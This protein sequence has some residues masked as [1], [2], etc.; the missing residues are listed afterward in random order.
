MDA[1]RKGYYVGTGYMGW[2]DVLKRYVLFAT[3]AEY[4][5]DILN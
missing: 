3:E 5:D 1:K 4:E 2:V